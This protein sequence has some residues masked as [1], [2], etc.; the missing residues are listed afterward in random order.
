MIE[1]KDKV[2]DMITGFSG[3]AIAKSIYL[4]GCVQYLVQPKGLKDDGGK[5]ESEW[6]DEGQLCITEVAE[7]VPVVEDDPGGGV[8][9]SPTGLN[10]P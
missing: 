10:H 1:L 5:K 4:N 8:R 9:K 2:E 7:M 6:F 3:T